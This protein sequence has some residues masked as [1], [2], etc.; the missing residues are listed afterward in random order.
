MASAL[1]T[2]KFKED[3]MKPQ[4]GDAIRTINN[5]IGMRWKPV[6]FMMNSDKEVTNWIYEVNGMAV[7]TNLNKKLGIENFI[8]IGE[9][10]KIIEKLKKDLGKILAPRFSLE[11]GIR[12]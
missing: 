11:G 9:S 12:E 2:P 7:L 5:Y 3:V 1:Y 10:R 4:I 8:I 6:Y